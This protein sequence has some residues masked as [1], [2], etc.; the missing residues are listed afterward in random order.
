MRVPK[1]QGAM[2]MYILIDIRGEDIYCMLLIYVRRA[3]I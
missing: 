2:L 1:R 3:I